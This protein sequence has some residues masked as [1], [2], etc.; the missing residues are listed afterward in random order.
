[1]A[2]PINTNPRSN[3]ASN[4]WPGSTMT[5]ASWSVIGI[6]YADGNGR[7]VTRTIPDPIKHARTALAEARDEAA[8]SPAGDDWLR[9]G[10]GR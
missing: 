4:G 6:K 1:M 8:T 2:R 10:S 9:H 3:A 7:I 5:G